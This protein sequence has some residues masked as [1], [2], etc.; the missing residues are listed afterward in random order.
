M[1]RKPLGENLGK[2]PAAFLDIARR[3]EAEGKEQ[4]YVVEDE[5]AALAARFDLYRFQSAVTRAA[6]DDYPRF[7]VARMFLARNPHRVRI[8]HPDAST[9]GKV[10]SPGS[11]RK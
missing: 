11:K 10:V 6:K 7:C 9:A 5:K 8:V 4:W 1:S 2:F 3:F